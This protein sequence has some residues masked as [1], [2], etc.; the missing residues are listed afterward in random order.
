MTHKITSGLHQQGAAWN[1]WVE[2]YFPD[3]TADD[4]ELLWWTTEG[5]PLYLKCVR[6]VP[7]A[8]LSEKLQ[9]FQRWPSLHD[10]QLLDVIGKQFIAD[11]CSNRNK[12]LDQYYIAALARVSVGSYDVYRFFDYDAR[13]FYVDKHNRFQAVCGIVRSVTAE[14]GYSNICY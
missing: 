8:T 5:L 13:F 12:S 6:S 1:S 3:A 4:A 2:K 11:F 9:H 14:V 7:K 10:T